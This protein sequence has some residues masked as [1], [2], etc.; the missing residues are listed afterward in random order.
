[1]LAL[2]PVS[3]AAAVA[4]GRR[5][6]ERVVLSRRPHSAGSAAAGWSTPSSPVLCRPCP[7]PHHT[8]AQH[9]TAQH[10]VRKGGRVGMERAAG[11]EGRREGRGLQERAGGGRLLEE[12]AHVQDSGSH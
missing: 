8:P 11:S 6:A 2:R 5:E 3:G 12:V 7:P 4:A 10:S 1:M 9:S